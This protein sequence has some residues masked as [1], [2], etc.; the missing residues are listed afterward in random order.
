MNKEW[1]ELNK[2]M[3]TQIKKKDTYDSGIGTLFSLRDNLWDMIMHIEACLRI[4]K[5]IH[6]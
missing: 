6:S 3:Q 4:K 1:S 5:K 2:L